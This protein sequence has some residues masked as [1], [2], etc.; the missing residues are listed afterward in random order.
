MRSSAARIVPWLGPHGLGLCRAVYVDS[1]KYVALNVLTGGPTD[2]TSSPWQG[3]RSR[4][5]ARFTPARSSCRRGDDPGRARL[6][7]CA[8]LGD[9]LHSVFSPGLLAFASAV[10]DARAGAGSRPTEPLRGDGLW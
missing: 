1:A 9:A 8:T 5:F 4:V 7:M 2:A 10:R 3:Q 6:V